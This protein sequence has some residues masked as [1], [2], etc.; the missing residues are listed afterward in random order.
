M[1][2]FQ[3]VLSYFA[4]RL[5]I[6]S[7]ILLVLLMSDKDL[8]DKKFDVLPKDAIINVK[9]TGQYYQDLKT[10]FSNVLIDG[11]TKDDIA[12]ILD[13]LSNDLVTSMK[14]RQLYSMYILIAQIEIDARE[15]GVI[16]RA[17]AEEGAKL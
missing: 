1:M 11:E 15:Q 2:S 3:D 12:K 9:L 4:V 5:F 6:V 13:N 7:L 8:S 16:V 14:E 17:T 10:V